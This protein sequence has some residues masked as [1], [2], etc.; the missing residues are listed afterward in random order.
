MLSAKPQLEEKMRIEEE[1]IEFARE[2]LYTR[3]GDSK[4][5]V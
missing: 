5:G 4:E 1:A 2:Y 3:G